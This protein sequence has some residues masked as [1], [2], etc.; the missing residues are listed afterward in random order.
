[1]KKAIVLAIIGIASSMATSS[2]GQ[3]A[4]KLDNYTTTGP[5]VTYGAGSDGAL[6]AGVT[7]AYT[8]G[9]YYWN[10]LGDHTGGTAADPSGTALPTSLGTF[11]LASGSGS[12]AQFQTT[13]FG[14]AG[15]AFSGPIYNVPIS[16]ATGG[17][18]ITFMVVAYEGASYAA[19]QFRGHSAAFNL[20]TSD[21]TAPGTVKTGSGMAAFQVFAAVPEPTTMALGGLGL[22]ALVLA[23]RKKA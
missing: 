5:Y 2:Y 11:V 7:S 23:R 4:I 16:A 1:M 13:T 8:M 9:L 15:T 14:L 12:T 22:A 18:T 10:A 20:V 6:G 19:A 21:P 3:G 17:D